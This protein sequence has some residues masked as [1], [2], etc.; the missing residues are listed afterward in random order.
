[1]TLSEKYPDG[2]KHDD[3][4][5]RYDLIPPEAMRA[6][7]AVMTHGAKKYDDNSW[8]NLFKTNG[9][10]RYTAALIRHIEAWRLGEQNDPE[11]GIHHLGH[12]LANVAFLLWNESTVP[13]EPDFSQMKD[14]L[15]IAGPMRGYPRYNFDMFADVV[16]ILRADGYSCVSP[17]EKDLQAGFNPDHEYPEDEMRE[18]LG[19][20]F[21]WDVRAVLAC[22]GIVLL[23][24]WE[25]SQG[26]RTEAKIALFCNKQLWMWD[27]NVE[28]IDYT[29]GGPKVH[30]LRPIRVLTAEEEKS[31]LHTP[32]KES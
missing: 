11:S 13:E 22:K 6:L 23:P 30:E 25:K 19:D 8:Q 3:G 24:G 7:A 29:S 17:H 18:F 10:Q 16:R 12:A 21:T 9:R 5:L 4:K 27:L 20:A 15:Y 26:A 28:T 1:M 31:I 14:S 2:V 32:P